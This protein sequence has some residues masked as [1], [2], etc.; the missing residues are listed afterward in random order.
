MND[1]TLI[2]AR[3]WNK[4]MPTPSQGTI[5]G[6]LLRRKENGFSKCVIRISNRLYIDLEEYKNWLNEKR[7]IK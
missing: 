1:L 4:F 5:N 2:P 6:L 7:E 3:Q